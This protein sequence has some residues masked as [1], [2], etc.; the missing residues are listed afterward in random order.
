MAKTKEKEK[1]QKA[2]G[3]IVAVESALS[4][5]EQFI[6]KNK[7]LLFYIIL[8]ILVVVGGYFAYQ[9]YIQVPKEREAQ[10]A[11]FAAEHYFEIDS[12]NLAL[13]GDQTNPGFLGII[14]EYGSTKSG[15]LAEYYAGICYLKLGKFQDA[16]DYLDD[17]SSDDMI[18]GPMAAGAAGDA[19][20]E[21]NENQKALE[22][23]MKAAEMQDNDFTTSMFLMK[24]AWVHEMNNDYAKSLELYEKIK[25]EHTR[26]FEAR[27]VDKY[28]A[29]AKVMSGQK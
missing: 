25:K 16:I 18:I 6:E 8:G 14:D 11:M 10:A 29:K 12:L 26:S 19:Y 17:F 28:I 5:G 22:Y 23:Y 13:N 9:R 21:L 4:K 1:I 27:D 2:E 20:L 3:R 15:N 7:N 24:A